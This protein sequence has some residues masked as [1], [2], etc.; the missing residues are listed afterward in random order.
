M[1]L[2]CSHVLTPCSYPPV[3]G[4]IYTFNLDINTGSVTEN[5]ISNIVSKK[6]KVVITGT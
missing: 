6:L 3:L 2:Y 4:A 5:D 1:C